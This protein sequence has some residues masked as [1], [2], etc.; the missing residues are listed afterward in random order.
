MA[1]QKQPG[2][3]MAGKTAAAPEETVDGRIYKGVGGFYT[4]KTQDGR[5]LTS[6]ARGVLRQRGQKPLAGDLVRLGCEAGTWFIDEILP[7]SNVF[8]RPPVANVDRIYIVASTAAPVPSFFVI[9]K[10][11]AVAREQEAEVVLVASKTDLAPADALLRPYR[12]AGFATVQVQEGDD[13]GLA[14]ICA[15]LAGHV[16]VFCGN[17]GVGKS[18]LLNALMP[19]VARPT[20]EISQKL[21]RGKHTTREVEIFEVAGGLV[22]DTP[23]FASFDVQRAS[24]IPAENLQFDFPEMEKRMGQ[25][26]YTGCT[27]VAEAGCAV[28]AAVENGEMAQSRYDSYV[29]LYTEAK[30]SEK[31][32]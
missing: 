24:P 4:V 11:C 27:H 6:R 3:P 20:A 19:E 29:A 17:S 26:R 25:C 12:M 1:T 10:L 9:D 30:E 16:S 21:G 18:T 8:V 31:S 13:A 28:K 15:G 23:G 7:R 22:A 32:Y 2:T 5:L 14:E